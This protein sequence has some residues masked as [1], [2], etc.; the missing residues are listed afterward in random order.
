MAGAAVV[1]VALAL[2][3]CGR[4]GDPLPPPNPSAPKPVATNGEAPPKSVFLPG[5]GYSSEKAT[6]VVKPPPGPFVL[7]PVLN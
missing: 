7:D 3:G 5:G 6:P 2:S 4:R 1:A